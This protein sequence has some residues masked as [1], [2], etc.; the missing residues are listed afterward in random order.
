MDE[1]PPSDSVETEFDPVNVLTD[2]QQAGPV[3]DKWSAVTAFNWW[4]VMICLAR[5]VL[6]KR[7]LGVFLYSLCLFQIIETL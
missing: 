6:L 1:L 3:K 4:V 5:S 7:A 2:F